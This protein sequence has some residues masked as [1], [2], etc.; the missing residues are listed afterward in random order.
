MGTFIRFQLCKEEIN[1]KKVEEGGCHHFSCQCQKSPLFLKEVISAQRGSLRTLSEPLN[2]PSAFRTFFTSVI[3]S[4]SKITRP[5]AAAQ[6]RK[7]V[8]TIFNQTLEA[9]Y[10]HVFYPHCLFT[11]CVLTCQRKCVL[12]Q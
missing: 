7:I 12:L 8:F 11:W 1:R 5:I 9:E 2:R 3:G 10:K 6:R 4:G